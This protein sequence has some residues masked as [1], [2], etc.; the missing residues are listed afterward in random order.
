[1]PSSGRKRKRAEKHPY[2]S[3][4]FAPVKEICSA[5][6]CTWTGVLP[7]EL[8]G[9]QY[10]RNGGNPVSNE[11]LGRDA[12]WF[13][14]DGMLAGVSFQR[15]DKNDGKV[16][17]HF[18]N[19]NILTDLYISSS[20]S[21][22]RT[23]ILPSIATLVN[24]IASLVTII[25]R[26]LRTVFLVI[27]SHLPGSQH[28]IKRISVANTGILYHDGRALATCESGP[29]MRI[30][31]P[32]LETV[33]WYDG[34]K[35]EGELDE[36]A[37][38]PG[39]GG[40]GLFS[41]IKEWTTG[42][43]K[44]DP[45]TGEM[46][47]FH[48]TFL[49]PYLHYSVI[50]PVHQSR[51]K[52]TRIS[53]ILNLPIPGVS[54]GKMMHDFGVSRNHTVIMDLPLSLDPFN[55]LKNN[56]V[57]SFDPSK[58]SR[59]GIFPRHDPSKARWFETSACCI[60]HTASSWDTEDFE[61]NTLNV[62]LLA[63]R[64]TSA[65][66]IFSAGNVPAPRIAQPASVTENKPISFFAKCDYNEIANDAEGSHMS[67]AGSNE[68]DLKKHSDPERLPLLPKSVTTNPSACSSDL[69]E[70]E[71]CRLYYYKFSFT[72]SKPTITS[73]YALSAVAFEYP[74]LNPA[75]QMSRTRYIYGCSTSTTSFETALGGAVKIDVLVKVD[76]NALIQRGQ[77][78]PPR[79]VTGC[80]DCRS[81]Q[82]VIRSTD[83]NDP[84]KCF[85]MPEG[86]YAQEAGF[87]QRRASKSAA[88]TEVA[89]DDGF[90]LFY[91]FD[92]SQLNEHGECPET[93][94][95]ELWILD[96]KNFEDVLARVRLPQRVPYGL[97]GNW[98]TEEMIQNQR[99]VHSI[100]TVSERRPNGN[101]IW[102]RVKRRLIQAVG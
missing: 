57:V 8:L 94:V 1:M 72:S 80:V 63:C 86:W 98:F 13:D 12:H 16:M 92:E 58:P 3:G 17:A 83:P 31:L 59:F 40:T 81:V 82:E 19:R 37:R 89:E 87:V 90:L 64:L 6:P 15:S 100:R 51:S 61:G 65:S 71:Q 85:K 70:E 25:L 22:S 28:A 10:I 78:N 27:L 60:F 47:L 34:N 96:A 91:A 18:V 48:C 95:S 33:G 93:A 102:G 55:L 66:L 24:P 62:N 4:N 29:P 52:D 53:K 84:I 101:G 44:V 50:P 45:V 97:H 32:G 77:Q 5:T 38:E 69:D 79:S 88:T 7:D 76:V 11:D 49:P 30:Q 43:P 14:G 9:G 56:P 99:V 21:P 35:A 2:L 23:P 67:P 36:N 39:F 74:T 26:I 42:H 20:E 75:F 41:F 68:F 73:Q 46:L 54:G